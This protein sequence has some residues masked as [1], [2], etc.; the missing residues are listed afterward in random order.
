MFNNKRVLESVRR[1]GEYG[2]IGSRFHNKDFPF[3]HIVDKLIVNIKSSS[4][5]KEQGN[6]VN[7]N[8]FETVRFKESQPDFSGKESGTLEKQKFRGKEQLAYN[9]LMEA[10]GNNANFGG[11]NKG[12]DK[13]VGKQKKNMVKPRYKIKGFEIKQPEA[14]PVPIYPNQKIVYNDVKINA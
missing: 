13:S 14:Y 1:G 9:P 5:G 6:I 12:G 8:V 11:V 7:R 2:N 10:M 3:G 4:G